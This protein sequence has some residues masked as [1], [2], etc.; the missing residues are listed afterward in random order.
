VVGAGT[1]A[2]SLWLQVPLALTAALVLALLGQRVML[3]RGGRRGAAPEA[4]VRPPTP[5]P[6]PAPAGTE[7]QSGPPSSLW[8]RVDARRR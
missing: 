2:V 5:P 1:D 7:P 6:A 8:S 4:I 3:G